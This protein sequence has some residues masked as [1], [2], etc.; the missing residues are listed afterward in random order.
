MKYFIVILTI[1]SLLFGSCV[2][3]RAGVPWLPEARR[4]VPADSVHVWNYSA[5]DIRQLALRAFP[6]AKGS[7]LSA[8]AKFWEQR[9]DIAQWAA[10][11]ISHGNC[12]GGGDDLFSA[13]QGVPAMMQTGACAMMW[14]MTGRSEY[15]DFMERAIS[16]AAWHAATDTLLSADVSD[17]RA[18]AETLL[19][20]PAT[21]YGVCGDSLFVNY[22]TNAT[23]RIPVGEGSAFTLDLITQMP[24]SGVVKFRFSQLPAEGRFLA[25]HLRLPDWTGC[26][27]ANSVYHYEGNEHA[28]LP[29]IF[30]NG[31]ELLPK[32]FRVDEKGYVIIEKTW[33]NMDE[34]YFQI[35][36]PLLQ[37]TSFR[38]EETG[39]S[40]LQ[41]GPLVYVLPEEAKGFCFT[42]ASE[43]SIV[44]IDEAGLPVLS[45]K[46]FPG[47]TG[48]G[49]EESGSKVFTATPYAN[50]T[51]GSVFLHK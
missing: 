19:A 22:Y 13:S 44:S 17:R 23:S 31:H 20:M 39:R 2:E 9:E 48:G 37:V 25:L 1:C 14:L 29:A 12:V 27:G 3:V 16:N 33:F 46:L 18:A 51:K 30:V 5:P 41:R 6:E 32:M 15:A 26:S 38:P 10:N 21:M 8:D 40:F 45:V 36:L 11:L 28:T 42:S 47:E 50:A 24:I 49:N 34:V 7:L 4:F 43:T 35:P